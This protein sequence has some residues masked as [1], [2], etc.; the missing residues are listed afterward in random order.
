M[1]IHKEVTFQ[2]PPE[3]IY[4]LLTNGEEF[5]AA[6]GMPATIG[7]GEGA[8]F[9]IFGGH[10]IG[11]QIELVPGRSVIQ[12]WRGS[13]WQSGVYSV[14]RFTLEADGKGTKLSMDHNAYP[15]GKSPRYPT[16]QEHLSTNWPV[17][18]FEPF[19]QYLA[20]QTEIELAA[21]A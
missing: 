1:S 11:R 8:A 9:S 13:D 5:A 16:W 3:Q 20:G 17:F 12:A 6:T 14:V 2:A 10:I 18:Y 4:N 21:R 7:A 15:E 19:A